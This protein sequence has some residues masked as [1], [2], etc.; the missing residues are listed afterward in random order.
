MP[1]AASC[2]GSSSVG[3]ATTAARAA[4]AWTAGSTSP[5]RPAGA[6]GPRGSCPGC[7]ARARE[8]RCS[9]SRCRSSERPH[10]RRRSATPEGRGRSS[11]LH[12][13]AHQDLSMIGSLLILG[14][15]LS[16]DNFRTAIA[17]GGLHGTWR[18]SVQVAAMFGFWDGTAV[19]MGILVGHY[20]N[21][22]MG[23]TAE[24]LGA[25]AL[26][27]YGLYLV[28]RAWR[29]PEPEGLD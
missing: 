8:A 15:V 22:A 28:I 4:T 16:L 20:W 2:C 5:C 21:D 12:Q 7:W 11:D 23:S 29:T 14:F 6:P 26:G 27:G 1:R 19:L 10:V 9:P 17:L 24:Y 3:A 13:T 25:V 18:R